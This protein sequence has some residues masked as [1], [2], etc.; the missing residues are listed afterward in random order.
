VPSRTSAMA[1]LICFRQGNFLFDKICLNE[2][3]QLF[4]GRNLCSIGF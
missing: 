3:S 4:F 1:D 2:A